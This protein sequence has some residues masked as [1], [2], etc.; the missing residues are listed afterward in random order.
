MFTKHC[1]SHLLRFFHL[2]N[3]EGLPGPGEPDYDPCA[4]YQPLV[5]RA[6]RVFGHHYTPHQEISVDESLVGTKNKNSLMQ[7]LPNK[8]HHHWGI[9][10]W[11]LCNCVLDKNKMMDNVQKHACINVPLS[12][13]LRSYSY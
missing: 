10:F 8:Q 2:V 5:D 11:L 13:T 9:K 7:Y 6:D 4:R 3:K 1:F 12:Q